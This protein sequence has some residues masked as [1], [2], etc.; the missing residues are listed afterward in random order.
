MQTQKPSLRVLPNTLTKV[1]DQC[2]MFERYTSLFYFSSKSESKQPICKVP[3]VPLTRAVSSHATCPMES[4]FQELFLSVCMSKT[5]SDL[6]GIA[7]LTLPH[8]S[9]FDQGICPAVNPVDWYKVA[10]G[11]YKVCQVDS[12]EITVVVADLPDV[13]QWGLLLAFARIFGGL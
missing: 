6:D 11:G 5:A 10:M 8:R 3:T 7:S 4:L 12:K 13:T 1:A 9:R 2:H